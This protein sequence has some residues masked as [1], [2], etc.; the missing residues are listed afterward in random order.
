VA[1]VAGTSLR[2]KYSLA[3][4][5]AGRCRAADALVPGPAG[6][7]LL[8]AM[9]N[10][11]GF[12]RHAQKQLLAELQ[13]LE[14]DATLLVVD[15][16]AGLT[17]WVR[18]FWLRA[19]LVMLVTTAENSALLDSYTAIKR[20]ARDS[21][22]ADIRILA[23]QCD[24]ATIADDVYRRLAKAS[25]RFLSRAVTALPALPRHIESN[26]ADAHTAPRAWETPNSPFG[27]AMLWLGRAVS[28]ALQLGEVAPARAHNIQTFHPGKFHDVERND[29][30][31]PVT[32]TDK[33]RHHTGAPVCVKLAELRQ[34]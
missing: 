31:R 34:L 8:P 15:C 18:R 9:P 27:H 30:R 19:K 1:H 12:T 25:E 17:P 26:S 2:I 28:D 5:A 10:D 6:T 7:K 22:P 4:V 14:K 20:S 3:D 11:A 32:N 23:N 29:S 33:V 21:I 16:G 13:T 24:R